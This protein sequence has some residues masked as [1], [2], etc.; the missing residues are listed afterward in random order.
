M[1]V[2]KSM[3]A[4]QEF[5][6]NVVRCLF[7]KKGVS[8]NW[9]AVSLL[10]DDMASTIGAPEPFERAVLELCLIIKADSTAKAALFLPL[11]GDDLHDYKRL[12]K[13][14]NKLGVYDHQVHHWRFPQFTFTAFDA[15]PLIAILK[16]MPGRDASTGISKGCPYTDKFN[17]VLKLIRDGARCRIAKKNNWLFS[18]KIKLK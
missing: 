3:E 12:Y 8:L 17:S 15:R 13:A 5:L 4:E 11:L 7:I 18:D 2:S 14:L 1:K 6:V 9:T 16:K 10:G